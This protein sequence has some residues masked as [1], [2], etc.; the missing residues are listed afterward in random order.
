VF[1]F[2]GDRCARIVR[3]VLDRIGFHETSPTK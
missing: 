3:Q 1:P 2:D